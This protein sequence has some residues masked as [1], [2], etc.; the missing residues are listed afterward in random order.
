M[1]YAA[2]DP[3]AISATRLIAVMAKLLNSAAP[4]DAGDH[5]EETLSS[6]TG[7]G[8]ASGSFGDLPLVLERERDEDVEREHEQHRRGDHH[9]LEHERLTPVAQVAHT[10]T[11]RERR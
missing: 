9:E 4:S 11:S 3:S 10:V 8:T 1:K 2:V 5:A 6:V 7:L